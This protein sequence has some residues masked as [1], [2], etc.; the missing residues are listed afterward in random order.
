MLF[1]NLSESSQKVLTIAAAESRM[2]KHFYVGT[3]HIFIGLCKAGDASVDDIFREFSIDPLIRRE[4]RARAGMGDG[5]ASGNEMIFTPRAQSIWKLANETARRYRISQIEPLHLL[6]ALLMAGDGVALRMLKDHGVDIEGMLSVIRERL[7]KMEEEDRLSPSARKTPLLNKI[8]RDLTMLARQGEL[9]PVIG[10]KPEIRK[11]AQILTQK[12]KNSPVLIGEAGVG[13][14]AV[15]EGL[16][17]RLV[18]ED[19]PE[20][21]RDLRI[22]EISLTALVA[23]T[24]YRGD[25]EE[26]IL[27]MVE[28]ARGNREVVLFIDE[29]HNM[30]GAGSASG[31]LD[32]S[33]ILKPA[34]A[35]GEI[36]CIGATT[37]AEYRQ[38]IERDAAL[39]R[40]FQPVYIEEPTGGET[41]Q[42]IHGLKDAYET[43]HQVEITD[44]AV[45]AAVDLSIQYIH[46]RRLPDK[47]IDLIDQASS[48]K[49]LA[50]LT[51]IEDY[52]DAA[53]EKRQVT[54]ED[55]AKV[56]SEWTGIPVN[57]LTSDEMDRL[58]K[59]EQILARSVIGQDEAVS[60][61][62]E[63]IRTA[64]AG[65]RD[66]HKPIGVFFFV[67]ATGVGKTE[68]AKRLAEYLFGDQ[69]R[70]IRI[71][72]SEYMEKHSVARLIGSPPGYIGHEEEGQLTGAVRTNP[73]SV[74]LFDEVEKA[75]PEVM[76][77]FLQIFDD[78]HLTDSR[79]RRVSFSETVIVLTSNL[80][81]LAKEPSSPLGFAR[82]DE[83]ERNTQTDR[84]SYRSQIMDAVRG[85]LRPELLNRIQRMV[86]FYPLDEVSVRRI[87]DKFLEEL[88][89]RLRERSITIQLAESAY[90]HLMKVG[91]DRRFGARE[92]ERTVDRLIV[93]PL[94]KALLE[95]RF[96]DGTVVCVESHDGEMTLYDAERTLENGMEDHP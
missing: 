82:V 40:R 22:I 10:R 77:I 95:G 93:H 12:N 66:P 25:F 51:K 5:V 68:L 49:R 36:R 17:S 55:I 26:R 57:R 7:G 88:G 53:S 37:M 21:L 4:L 86:F 47:A 80:G 16:A 56:V 81:N 2:L 94:G 96:P 59:M 76:D 50:S 31:S 63:V 3:E 27:K 6:L 85:T 15:V 9:D 32:A 45:D 18:R 38:H 61:V 70:L 30:V 84:E 78:G 34:L 20:E 39:E 44:K 92:M 35:R 71:D 54:W 1:G 33:N 24:R 64:R 79:G 11:I 29:L 91:F 65:L 8:G 75:H 69:R 41:R 60:A 67:G 87:I 46:D 28:E 19:I 83:V 62:S 23:G 14:T 74:V 58:L 72:M 48:R 89:L 90:A 43:Y 13:K 73:Y 42:I 52:G